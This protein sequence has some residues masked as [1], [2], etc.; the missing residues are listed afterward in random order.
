MNTL[1]STLLNY[2]VEMILVMLICALLSGLA[3]TGTFAQCPPP[4]P[5][6]PLGPGEVGLFFDAAGTMTCGEVIFGFSAPLYLVGCAPEGGI[7]S[8]AISELMSPSPVIIP[9]GQLPPGAPF[10][11]QIFVDLCNM[12]ERIDPGSCPV[13]EGELFVLTVYDVMFLVVS[14]TVCFQTAC[15]T[16]AG[17]VSM[18]PF[19]TRC[20]TGAG[21]ELAGGLLLCIGL[22]QEPVPVGESTWGAVKSLYSG[23]L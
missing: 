23:G 13:A 22:G 8:Y 2:A 17:R 5:T 20:D 3:P 12:A 14:G 15:P 16:F 11:V 6:S 7:A 4:P 1:R 18:N 9:A 21:D 19:Y 10:N